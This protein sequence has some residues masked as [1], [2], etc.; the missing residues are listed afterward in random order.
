MK[1]FFNFLID[2]FISIFKRDETLIEYNNN[3]KENK[4]NEK[5]INENLKENSFDQIE[6]EVKDSIIR[7]GSHLLLKHGKYLAGLS[8]EQKE[9]AVHIAYL[10]SIKNISTFSF[11]ELKEY[12]TINSKAIELG[13]DVSKEMNEFWNDFGNAVKIIFDKSVELSF[14]SI[15]VALKASILI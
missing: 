12:S 1:E 7:E 14:K 6:K 5:F 4:Q 2:L 13:I 3:K 9:Y 10:K 15:A 8:K 11:K